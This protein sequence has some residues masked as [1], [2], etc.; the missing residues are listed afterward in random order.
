MSQ[1]GS[2]LRLRRRSAKNRLRRLAPGRRNTALALLA[3]LI[4]FLIVAGHFAADLLMEPP[5]D[6]A[7]PRGLAEDELPA[8]AAALE[9]AFWLS[10]L[11]ASVLNFRVLELL[12]RRPD[13]VALQILPIEPS[14][15]FADRLVAAWTEAAVAAGVASVFFVPLM[16][17]GGTSAALASMAMLFGGLVFGACISLVVM[18][19]ATQRLIPR[20]DSGRD[21]DNS[22]VT[23][24]YGGPG[25]LLLYAPAVAL[26]GVV[27]MALFW[28]L[29]LGEPLRLGYFSEP[30]WI[31]TAVVVAT[32]AGCL[33]SAYRI[34][35]SDYYAMAP[36]FHDADAADYSA[37]I[38]YQTSS[39]DDPGRWEWGLS[40][41]AARTLRI[42]LLDDDRRMAS[43]RVGFAVV[44]VIAI[45]GLAIIE[46]DAVPLWAAAM[47][48]SILVAVFVNPWRRLGRRIRLLDRPAALPIADA[49]A[50][51][52]CDRAALR[53]FFYVGAPYALAVAVI[54]GHL[55]GL[56]VQGLLTAALSIVAG[57]ATAAVVSAA[58]RLGAPGIAL[59][60]LPA[61]TVVVV[62]VV[63][64]VSIPLAAAAS[65]GT[66][67]VIYFVLRLTRRDHVAD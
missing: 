10:V 24:A 54:L 59:A 20:V 21:S 30:F 47:I 18:L 46:L 6:L 65:A 31:G 11:L 43:A 7:T 48:P 14:A 52:A 34:F 4:A 61:A 17:H 1:F 53:E 55:R 12:F 8:G 60:W 66:A 45:V 36:R 37:L 19:A 39:F 41:G 23:D 44:V 15:L 51:I 64:I 3:A 56:G 57:L 27:V 50:E 9:A 22:V 25:Q 49:D 42:L 5:I 62:T 2:I 33:V 58:R 40:D 63:A 16:W 13:V 67:A 32:S 28:K 29:L 26:G 38:E 35:V